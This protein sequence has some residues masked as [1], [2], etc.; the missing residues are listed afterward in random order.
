[1]TNYKLK[2]KCCICG[3]PG[4]TIYNTK[5]YCEWCWSKKKY[6]KYTNKEIKELLKNEMW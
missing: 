1:M 5:T 4:K 3:E 6:G 2:S